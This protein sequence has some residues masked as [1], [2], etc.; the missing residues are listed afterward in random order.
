M[1][2]IAR[3]LTI[4]AAPDVRIAMSP[5]IPDRTAAISLTAIPATTT[6]PVAVSV[7]RFHWSFCLCYILCHLAIAKLGRSVPKSFGLVGEWGDP[8][9]LGSPKSFGLVSEQVDVIIIR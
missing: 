2:A 1:A 3:R 5:T 6:T 7:R 9:L 8:V 4:L